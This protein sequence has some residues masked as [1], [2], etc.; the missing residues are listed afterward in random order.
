M[1]RSETNRKYYLKNRDRLAE[2]WK[3][4]PRRKEYWKQYYL[5]HKE[6]IIERAKIWN[7]EHKEAK[8]LFDQRSKQKNNR[9]EWLTSR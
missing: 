7:N 3:N 9:Q 6:I 1:T 4:D 8:R 5:E 2:K